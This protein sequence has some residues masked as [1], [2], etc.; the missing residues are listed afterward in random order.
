MKINLRGLTEN[1]DPFYRYKMEKPEIVREK[2]KTVFKNIGVL[3]KDLNRDPELMASF[4][5]SRLG[6]NGVYKKDQ[7]MI[8]GKVDETNLTDALYEFI[9]YFVLCPTC[10]LPETELK[11]GK[12]VR[13]SCKCCSYRGSIND[14]KNKYVIKLLTKMSK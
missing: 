12:T 10:K 13:M 7:L 1:N 4:I 3:A 14:G 8:N 9:E 11:T 6:I 5:K 2:S